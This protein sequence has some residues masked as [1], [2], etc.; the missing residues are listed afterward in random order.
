[1][2]AVAW[3]MCGGLAA[4][5]ADEVVFGYAGA[6]P[7]QQARIQALFVLNRIAYG[8]RPGDVERVAHMGIDRYIEEQLH[9]ERIPIPLA[10]TGRLESL[11]TQAMPTGDLLLEY[12]NAM[13]QVQREKSSIVQD[14][15]ARK[16]R[17]Q[18]L[19]RMAEQTGEARLARAIDSPRQLEEV[20][21]DF[22]FNHFNV[23]YG[24]GLDRVF[25]PSYERDAIRPFA[26]GNFR[27]LLGATAKHPAMLFYLDN[28]LSTS[29]ESHAAYR[30]GTAARKSGGLKAKSSGL[31]ENFA[32]EIMELHTLG[33]ENEGKPGGYSQKDVTELARILTGWSFEARVIVRGGP[34]FQFD[35]DRHDQGTKFWLGRTVP[36]N[37]QAEGELALD[38]LANHPATAR[39]VSYQ[40]AQYFVADQPP[41]ALVDRMAERW[42]ATQGDIRAVLKTLFDSPEFRSPANFNAKFKTPYQYVVSAARAT[43]VPIANVRPLLG[44]LSQLGM[45]LYG[46]QTPDGYKNT[47]DAWLNPEGMTRRINFATALA[48]GKLPLAK[49][50]A[51]DDAYRTDKDAPGRAASSGGNAGTPN[52]SS[53][54]VAVIAN[55]AVDNAPVDADALM[56]TLGGSLSP[57]TRDAVAKAPPKLRA[58]LVLGSPDF[59]RR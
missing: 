25:V 16:E 8:P 35:A 22:W 38:V 47:E 20:M 19:A 44:A 5:P 34:S 58:A 37:G 24:K 18:K 2:A 43:G 29:N 39:H 14:D 9:P 41:P 40:I 10:L 57:K 13:R 48:A 45:P 56:A 1:M 54:A 51:E 55:V 30:A 17:R 28:W 42:L 50:V 3:L 15:E 31:N 46:C 23:F 26:L 12:R 7:E 59:M 52:G 49:G 36:P 32:R 33:V 21:V 4:A 6:S 11:T 27:D 53:G